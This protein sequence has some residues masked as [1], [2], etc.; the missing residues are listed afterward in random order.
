VAQRR[1][2]DSAGLKKLVR[3]DLDCV[4][5]KAL[6]K[7]PAR[8]YESVQ[9]LAADVRRYLAGQAV[10]ASLPSPLRRFGRLVR[11]KKSAFVV[12][13]GVVAVAATGLG[14][15]SWLILRQ[16]EALRRAAEAEKVREHFLLEAKLTQL[17]SL[18]A[19]LRAQGKLSEA[20]VFYR[21]LLDL[22]KKL[23]G[24]SGSADPGLVDLLGNLADVL[25]RQ[26]K[27][28]QA[29]STYRDALPILRT[30]KLNDLSHLTNLLASFELLLIREGKSA[31][32]AYLHQELIRIQGGQKTTEEKL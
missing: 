8:R 18:A 10:K 7:E 29:E 22:R 11:R 26:G 19:D 32:A 12:G 2:V 21:E 5:M 31:E 6:E 15:S 4:V 16:R 9:A 20:E 27:L 1:C 13:V 14:F 23:S 30:L 28:A 3:G 24:P 17:T 25:A